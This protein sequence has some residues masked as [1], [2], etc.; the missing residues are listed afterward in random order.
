MPHFTL[1]KEEEQ[2]YRE[3]R[4]GLAVI[5]KCLCHTGKCRDAVLSYSELL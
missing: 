2:K 4:L 1:Y 3:V 5:P